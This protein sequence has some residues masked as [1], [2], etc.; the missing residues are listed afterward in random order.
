MTSLATSRNGKLAITT[1]FTL[2]SALAIMSEILLVVRC[3]YSRSA[4]L[5]QTS[6]T[7]CSSSSVAGSNPASGSSGV[8][9]VA[10]GS[11]CVC[12]G[13]SRIACEILSA[14]SPGISV[15]DESPSSV[16]GYPSIAA[17]LLLDPRGDFPWIFSERTFCTA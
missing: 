13:R 14:S 8:P 9:P 2:S 11:G 6:L 7:Y 10:M 12:G 4:T 15:D 5:S 16:A 17:L 3:L 1:A